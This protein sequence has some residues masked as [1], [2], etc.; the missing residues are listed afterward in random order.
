MN[1][2]EVTLLKV[3]L[4]DELFAALFKALIYFEK[5]WETGTPVEVW[6][7][8]LIARGEL[9]DIPHPELFVERLFDDLP[10]D[11]AL[12]CKAV[13]FWMLTVEDWS[14]KVTALK[15]TL[16][17]MLLG[18][19]ERWNKVFSVFRESEE[20]YKKLGY[21][22]KQCDYAGK[23]LPGVPYGTLNGIDVH[24]LVDIALS[25]LRV[26]IC[27]NLYSILSYIDEKKGHI[28]Q[29]EVVRLYDGAVELR[30]K[31]LE[32]NV[33]NKYEEGSCQ[34]GPGSTMNGNVNVNQQTI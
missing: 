16:A 13:L 15:D 29:A 24:E 32:K 25:S 33:I 27:E 23:R 6:V 26:G 7:S 19:G 34:F 14:T 30:K 11:K 9:V 12:L 10:D 31:E 28:Y 20:D 22:V 4:E 2:E 5:E 3:C 18:Y 1:K 17:R 21:S 8:T